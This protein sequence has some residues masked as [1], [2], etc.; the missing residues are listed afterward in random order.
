[1]NSTSSSF[2]EEKTPKI[3]LPPKPALVSN[4]GSKNMLSSEQAP[5]PLPEDS[6][7][8]NDDSGK[9][10]TFFISFPLALTA[11]IAALLA[12]ALQLWLML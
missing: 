1:M 2:S 3:N 7:T 12:F 9:A 4:L 11:F 10:A 6:F 8:T 5:P